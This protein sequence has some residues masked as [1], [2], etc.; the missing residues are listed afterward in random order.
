MYTDNFHSCMR[1]HVYTK[2]TYSYSYVATDA[3]RHLNLNRIIVLFQSRMARPQFF[4]SAGELSLSVQASGALS[5]AQL[6][7]RLV[8]QWRGVNQFVT[9]L[10]RLRGP[11]RLKMEEFCV[12]QLSEPPY[13]TADSLHASYCSASCGTE[14]A[15]VTEWSHF[16]HFLNYRATLHASSKPSSQRAS[17][18]TASLLV[19]LVAAYTS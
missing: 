6:C 10:Y 5:L 14:F 7:S 15:I 2:P 12:L 19:E 17:L 3:W 13:W 9:L 8:Q 11:K 18:I 16:C 1:M 4:T